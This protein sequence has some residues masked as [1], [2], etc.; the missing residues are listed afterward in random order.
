MMPCTLVTAPIEIDAEEIYNFVLDQGH[1]VLVNGVE[2]VTLG[3][4]FRDDIVRH[5]YYGTD[6]VIHDL[7]VLDAQQ[8]NN[9]IIKVSEG[10]HQR[11]HGNGLV[12]GLSHAD[13]NNAQPVMAN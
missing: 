10:M 4:K 8:N 7:V 3:H 9:G 5:S 13:A 2:C 6:R 11:N 1:T 12:T